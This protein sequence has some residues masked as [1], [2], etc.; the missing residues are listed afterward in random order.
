M[1]AARIVLTSLS[2][3]IGRSSPFEDPSTTPVDILH[4]RAS[5]RVLRKKVVLVR[6]R[7]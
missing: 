5:G 3:V 2:G 1:H 7:I 4:F 6:M